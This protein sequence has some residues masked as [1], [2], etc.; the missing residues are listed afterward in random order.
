[1]ITLFGLNH[2]TADTDLR[3]RLG[4]DSEAIPRLLT[5]LL[6]VAAEA[7]VLCTCNRVEVYAVADKDQTEAIIRVLA[8]H[9]AVSPNDIAA[10]GYASTDARA[11]HHLMS[12]A[13]GLD[14]LVVGESQILGQV[15]D[16]WDLAHTHAATG[17]TLNTLFRYALEAGKHIRTQT[18]VGRGITSVAH[19]AVELARHEFG[20]LAD[21]RTLVLGAGRMARLACLSLR[22]AGARE[23]AVANRTLDH[24][25][26]LASEVD[27]TALP[28][29]TLPVALAEV[30]L[31]IT[32]ATTFE[33]LV[34]RP[35]LEQ[36]T[37]QRPDRPLL[38]ADLGVPRNVA[39]ESRA[40]PGVRLFDLDTMERLCDR[41]RAARADAAIEA[42]QYILEWVGRFT[43][44]QRERD[45]IPL[46]RQLRQQAEQVRDE[47]VAHALQAL[48]GLTERERHAV[49]KVGRAILNRLLHHPTVWLKQ[50]SDVD[51]RR[52]L[53]EMWGLQPDS[54]VENRNY[55][56]DR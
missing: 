13:A 48:P 7:I 38:V 15:R 11:V 12:V 36:A 51:Q 46:I 9:T 26:A 31:L 32:C 55:G 54:R 22:S 47:E 33:P 44:W 8:V 34:T 50:H 43:C 2:R 4:L 24:A 1:M 16:A 53:A 37:R 27:A 10:H 19:A 6:D 14:S 35:M 30:D 28:L 56:H 52:W 39:L 5:D 20:S 45:A 17:P 23:L 25:R 18:G 49:E 21:R 42:E 29:D 41:N 40:V 3:G